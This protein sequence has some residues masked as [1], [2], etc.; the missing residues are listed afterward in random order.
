MIGTE[1]EICY[2]SLR[3]EWLV[4]VVVWMTNLGGRKLR[5]RVPRI[6]I[7]LGKVFFPGFRFHF[8]SVFLCA[9]AVT[10]RTSQTIPPRCTIITVVVRSAKMGLHRSIATG[11]RKPVG[12]C[13]CGNY[14]FTDPAR[15]ALM[16]A[17]TAPSPSQ[18]DALSH[19]NGHIKTFSVDACVFHLVDNCVSLARLWWLFYSLTFSDTAVRPQ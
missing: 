11:F 7:I 12:A 15:L 17:F 14:A 8:C 18:Q 1:T 4:L 5:S 10:D 9:V 2:T 19:P 16:V 6:V 13:G 3:D